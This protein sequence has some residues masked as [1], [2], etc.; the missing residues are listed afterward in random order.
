MKK[1]KRKYNSLFYF[2][3]T[4][5]TRILLGALPKGMLRHSLGGGDTKIIIFRKM[6]R[7]F[8]VIFQ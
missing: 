8:L 2:Y 6:Q 1:T 7:L 4:A 3:H 5:T